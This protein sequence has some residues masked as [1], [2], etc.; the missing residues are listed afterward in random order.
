MTRPTA[1][2]SER[3][4]LT[5]VLLAYQSQDDAIIRL[6]WSRDVIECLN[7]PAVRPLAEKIAKRLRRPLKIEVWH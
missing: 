4:M 7:V 5:P 3:R 1:R 2:G 6:P